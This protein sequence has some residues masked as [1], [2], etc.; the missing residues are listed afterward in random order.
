MPSFVLHCHLSGLFHA[1]LLCS[2]HAI[3]LQ[4]RR[5]CPVPSAKAFEARACS[6]VTKSYDCSCMRVKAGDIGKIDHYAAIS[7]GHT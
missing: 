7:L 1:T 6:S 5:P 4:A 3:T 2:G